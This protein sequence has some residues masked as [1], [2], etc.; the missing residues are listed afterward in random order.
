[1]KDLATY[2]YHS[3]LENALKLIENGAD[4]NEK[5]G[6]GIRP[7]ISA[8]NSD[9]PETLRFVIQHGA[10]VNIDW[11]EP[12]REAIDYCIDGMIQNNR[13]KPYP[14]ALE[15]LK[16][17][18]ENRADLELRNEKGN[19]PIDVIHAYARNDQSLAK[20]K[21]FFRHLIP[22]IDELIKSH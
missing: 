3:D 11:G 21:S 15:M 2:I 13:E 12:V 22:N 9:Q 14:E 6:I 7:I 19:R 5:Y 8:I 17:L 20:L 16:I 1:M 4:I 18:L 10:N